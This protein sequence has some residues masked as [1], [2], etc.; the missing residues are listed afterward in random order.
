M[1]LFVFARITLFPVERGVDGLPCQRVCKL[2]I[3][4]RDVQRWH[5]FMS[6]RHEFRDQIDLQFSNMYSCI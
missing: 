5:F 1:L 2:Q 3:R 6:I 4:N